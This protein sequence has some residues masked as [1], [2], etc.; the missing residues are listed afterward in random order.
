MRT[1]AAI[2]P[3]NA[4]Q[5]QETK[6]EKSLNGTAGKRF[7]FTFYFNIEKEKK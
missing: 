3:S 7:L 5:G 2:K 1:G 4:W 6:A